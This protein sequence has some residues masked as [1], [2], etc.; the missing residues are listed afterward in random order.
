MLWGDGFA[1]IGS[2]VRGARGFTGVEDRERVGEELRLRRKP[3]GDA[4]TA[5]RG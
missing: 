4:T 3:G 2:V 5:E 1:C